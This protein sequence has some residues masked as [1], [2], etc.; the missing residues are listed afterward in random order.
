MKEGK[1][2]E[3][4]ELLYGYVLSKGCSE[5]ALLKRRHLKQSH[6]CLMLRTESISG[7]GKSK[8]KVW[9]GSVCTAVVIVTIDTIV[10]CLS[11]REGLK[12]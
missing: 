8:V 4:S 3:W 6:G 2:K 12:C 7:G 10:M 1:S 5:K 11:W 9:D